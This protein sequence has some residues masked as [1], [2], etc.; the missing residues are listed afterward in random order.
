MEKRKI[1]VYLAGDSTVQTYDSSRAPQAGWGQCISKYFIDDVQFF[2]HAIGGR[3]SKT[4]ITEGRLAEI[5]KQLKKDDYLFIQMG[6]NDSSKSRPERYTEPYEDYKDYLIQYIQIARDRKAIP[7]LITPVARLHYI[8]REFLADFGDYCNAMKE[9]AEEND[10]LLFDLMQ[11]SIKK[12]SSLGYDEIF[13][14]FRIAVNETDCTHFT[15]KG[16]NEIAKL[17]SQGIN[18]LSIELSNYVK[19]E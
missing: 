10:V 9:V 2:N 15:E 13:S 16:A 11:E 3:S 1:N 12:F 14:Y 5:E 17:V 19:G 8:R 18:D 6:H 7:I 4:F